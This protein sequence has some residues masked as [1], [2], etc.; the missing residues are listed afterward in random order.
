[1]A[2]YTLQVING[3][4][5]LPQHEVAIRTQPI[6]AEAAHQGTPFIFSK[7]VDEFLLP[8]LSCLSREHVPLRIEFEEGETHQLPRLLRFSRRS[9]LL[10]LSRCRCRRLF[11]HTLLLM[12]NNCLD[13]TFNGKLLRLNVYIEAEF[14][15]SLRGYWANT[16][17]F[18]SRIMGD[19]ISARSGRIPRF[20][21][22][23]P[24]HKIAH[25]RRTG[26]G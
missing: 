10:C 19:E 16:S 11:Y 7:N 25:S 17:Y 9:C 2:A 23:Q 6:Q 8:L 21:L 13:Q 4:G 5:S 26:E 15:C 12:L 1:M 18:R 24:A 14:T 22:Y 20:A 3:V